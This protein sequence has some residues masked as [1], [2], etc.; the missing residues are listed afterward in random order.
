MNATL[1]RL[2]LGK[3]AFRVAHP[4]DEVAGADLIVVL[5]DGR[6]IEKG[7]HVELAATAGWYQKIFDL[8]RA[9]GPAGETGT[10]AAVPAS[11]GGR[12]AA[13]AEGS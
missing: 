7:T 10:G 13:A 1:D 8:Q 12:K 11:G 9:R 4:L 3:T 6:I 2:R 5:Y